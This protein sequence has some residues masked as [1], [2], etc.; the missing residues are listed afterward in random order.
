MVVLMGTKSDGSTF[1]KEFS[2]RSE[3][4]ELAYQGIETIDLTPVSYT[5]LRAHET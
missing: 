5:H 3:E 1:E 2:E 4:I